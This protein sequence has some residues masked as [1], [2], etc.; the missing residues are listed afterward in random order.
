MTTKTA[1]LDRMLD[2]VVT[3]ELAQQLVAYRADPATQTRIAELAEKCNEG[4]LTAV[5]R[6]EYEAYVAAINMVSI[7]QAKARRVLKQDAA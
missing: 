4:L 5:E 1:V 3:P 7:L 2:T 6:E